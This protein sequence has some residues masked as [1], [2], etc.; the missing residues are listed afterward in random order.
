M[1]NK[2]LLKTKPILLVCAVVF[3][4]DGIATAADKEEKKITFDDHIKPIFREHCTTCHSE[5]DKE[6]DLALDSYSA[7][8]S[9]GSS[10]EVIKTGDPD[11]SRLYSLVTHAEGPFMPPDE[12]PMSKAKLD[13]I[14]VWIEQGM[15]ENSGSKIRRVSSAATAM[16]TTASAGRPDGPP[17]MP[18]T[19]LTQ[20][21]LEPNRSAAIS[22]LAASPW[23]P[24][25]AVGGQ[26][27]VVLYHAEN[28]GLLGII[29][30]PEGEPQ[31]ITFTR[32]GKQILIGGGRHSHSGCAVLVDVATGDRI[33]KVGD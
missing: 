14:K 28:R 6:S 21:V 8:L 20:P 2:M 3:G 17:P 11:G 19:L 7:T 24:L 16:L 31:S 1:N 25:I 32:D 26:E 30:F 23:A 5:S 22:A 15:P 33:A 4:I 9:G 12:D 13:L 10:G 29:P 18:E 27:Q